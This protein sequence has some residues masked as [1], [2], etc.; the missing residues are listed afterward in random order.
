MK[1]PYRAVLC[2]LRCT[3]EF[4]RFPGFTP[5]LNARIRVSSSGVLVR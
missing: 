4:R 2:F 1:R 3:D 5:F